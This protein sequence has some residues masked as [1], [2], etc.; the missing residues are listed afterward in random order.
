VWE[1][2]LPSQSTEVVE[3][4]ARV[5]CERMGCGRMYYLHTQ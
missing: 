1:D 4:G 3:S 2:V 5:I